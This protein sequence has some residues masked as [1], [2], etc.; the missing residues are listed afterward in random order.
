MFAHP[1]LEHTADTRAE[2]YGPER[3]EAYLSVLAAEP[4]WEASFDSARPGAALVQEGLPL[5]RGLQSRGWTAAG[6]D[7]GYVLLLPGSLTP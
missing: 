2:L 7:G 3:A 5:V 6:R 4:G 1:A